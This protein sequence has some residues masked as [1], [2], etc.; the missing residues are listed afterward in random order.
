[1]IQAAIE[2]A[3]K[4]AEAPARRGELLKSAGAK[5]MECA[6]GEGETNP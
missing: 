4:G 5:R 3:A 2:A 1:M 6:P